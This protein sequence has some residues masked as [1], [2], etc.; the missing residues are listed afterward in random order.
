MII[1]RF[2]LDLGGI[3]KKV[4]NV[5]ICASVRF[6]YFLQITNLLFPDLVCDKVTFV[7]IS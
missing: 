2:I 5:I 3:P 4:A 7:K 1:T 6:H